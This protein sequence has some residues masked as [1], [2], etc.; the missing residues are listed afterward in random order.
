MP[1][2]QKIPISSDYKSF[3]KVQGK[4]TRDAA[5]ES[6]AQSPDALHGLRLDN[7]TRM[8]VS[9]FYAQHS[10]VLYASN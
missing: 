4:L 3:L 7:K 6:I 9:N 1:L 10:S 8:S 5:L 2:G